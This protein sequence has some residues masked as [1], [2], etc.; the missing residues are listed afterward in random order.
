MRIAICLLLL[1]GLA[2]ADGHAFAEGDRHRYVYAVEDTVR[3]SSEDDELAFRSHLRW[4][5]V[6]VVGEVAEE[7]AELLVTFLGVDAGIRGP[8]SEH[9][10]ATVDEDTGE[11]RVGADDPL[12]GH[13]AALE[14]A[15]LELSVDP[16]TGE[17]GEVGGTDDLVARMKRYQR[18]RDGIVDPALI[19]RVRAAYA[20]AELARIWSRILEVPGEGADRLDLGERLGGHLARTWNDGAWEVAL[21]EDESARPT[22]MLAGAPKPVEVRM[23]ALEGSGYNEF[24]DEG[25]LLGGRG[26]IDFTL[27]GEAL[28]QPLEQHHELRWE[29]TRLP[30]P[31]EDEARDE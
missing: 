23:S 1:G 19:E 21:P 29:A 13:L 6:L 3:W 10:Y 20:P 24:S 4:V 25:L 9:R 26:A 12:F 15:T 31:G 22:V 7:R 14:G 16:R 17:V 8:A 27:A 5:F 30:W 18:R 11:E 2:A 28:T